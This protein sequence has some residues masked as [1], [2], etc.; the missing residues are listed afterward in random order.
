MW[1]ASNTQRGKCCVLLDASDDKNEF[2]RLTA[3][4]HLGNHAFQRSCI[5]ADAESGEIRVA[6]GGYYVF[7]D[8]LAVCRCAANVE[9][10][11]RVYRRPANDGD[12]EI[13][14]EDSSLGG[15]QGGGEGGCAGEPAFSSDL[16]A[17]IWLEDGDFVGINVKPASAVYRPNSA[18]FF[19]LYRLPL[20]WQS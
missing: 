9:F 15:S 2:R 19:G 20:F 3:W 6:R 4:T 1:P 18:S 13:L 5:T 16:F 10:R 7:Y 12:D 11:Q 17:V 8:H 14:L